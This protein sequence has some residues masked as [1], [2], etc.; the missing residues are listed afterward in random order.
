MEFLVTSRSFRN[1]S[2]VPQQHQKHLQKD[3]V[4][5]YERFVGIQ[6]TTGLGVSD[7]MRVL[8]EECICSEGGVDARCFDHIARLV[9]KALEDKYLSTFLQGH[10]FKRH[11]SDLTQSCSDTSSVSSCPSSSQHQQQQRQQQLREPPMSELLDPDHIWRRP[12]YSIINIGQIDDLGRYCSLLEQLPLAPGERGSSM[13]A[14]SKLG[15]AMKKLVSGGEV[16]PSQEEF[17]WRVADELMRE[18]TN[19]TIKGED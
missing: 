6:A 3:A 1:N 7:A 18:V 4:A 13:T 8:T 9:T 14:S 2:L 16:T 19:V 15:R 11:L 17:A 5:I 12:Q 10:H